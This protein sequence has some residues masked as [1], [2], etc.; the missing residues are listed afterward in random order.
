MSNEIEK[1]ISRRWWP[2]E[3][4]R[5]Y[6]SVISC[7]ACKS[8]SPAC[9]LRAQPLTTTRISRSELNDLRTKYHETEAE[10]ANLST[11]SRTMLNMNLKLQN[12]ASKTQARAL[13][14]ELAKIEAKVAREQVEMV[15]VSL[16]CLL[17]SLFF[18]QR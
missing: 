7:K 14:L 9:R 15:E 11:Q 10:T 17:R 4:E 3:K 16:P 6:N 12:S 2:I 8:E 1:R 5:S 18:R 13:D